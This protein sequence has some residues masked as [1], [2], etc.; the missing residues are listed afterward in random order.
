MT[1]LSEDRF[2]F[3]LLS[4]LSWL[5]TVAIIS[6]APPPLYPTP[7]TTPD[8]EQGS[9]TPVVTMFY[10]YY[11]ISGSSSAD[12][13]SQ[14]TQHG[15]WSEVEEQHYFANTTW[16]VKWSYDYEVTERGC[17]ISN[18]QGSVDVTFTLPQW[19]AP[20]DT[21]TSLVSAWNQ[22]LVALQIHENGHMRHGVLA[23][24]DVLQTLSQLSPTPSCETLKTTARIASRRVIR[25]YNHH[26]IE[27][28][29]ETNHGLTQ[30]AVFPPI[31][32]SAL[33]EVSSR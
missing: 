27:Y 25:Q 24:Q 8:N 22:F 12:I 30:G 13:Q 31:R 7:S 1:A 10:D 15:P 21:S 9:P 33:Q 4:T 28:D 17:E 29:R 26:D 32:P 19:E 16:H 6:P 20:P 3:N 11:P 14:M 18:L 23:A 5:V 2:V